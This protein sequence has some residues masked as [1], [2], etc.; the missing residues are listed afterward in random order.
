[1][2]TLST[3]H[4]TTAEL[5][6]KFA[7][8][9]VVRVVDAA[10]EFPVVEIDN[11]WASVR[12][13]VHGGQVL[14]YQPHDEA[15]V[16]WVS[17]TAAYVHGKSVRGGIPICWPWFGVHP[18]PA[19][20]SH[21]FARNLFWQL[22]AVKQDEDGC[23]EVLLCLE[24]DEQSRLLWPH[25]FQLQLKVSVGKTLSLALTMVN[26]AEESVEL[27]AALHSYFD[28]GDIARTSV[29]GLDGVEYIDALQDSRRFTQSGNVQF[30]AELDR[31]Y[32]QTSGDEFIDDQLR[33]RL[34]HLQKSRSD[35]TVVWNPWIEKS[36]GMNDFV[37]GGY[38]RM[39]CV[40]TGN[41][42]ADLVR[43]ATGASHTLGVTI[44][45]QRLRDN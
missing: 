27:T 12:I 4:P 17:D 18:D 45:V 1:M 6:A 3:G 24:D 41:M 2:S 28:V 37:E 38:R 31:I 19:M 23:T 42:G 33:G 9:D 35:S 26:S 15:P 44:S 21:G 36:A 32:Q 14:S 29:R 5:H 34:I 25:A 39:V 30:D 7:I 16:L 10:S 40:E 13:A 11:A 43:L 22:I 8:D 20:P